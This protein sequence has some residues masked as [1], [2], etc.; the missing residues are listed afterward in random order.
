MTAV[1]IA[2]LFS[3]VAV[4]PSPLW[5][6]QFSVP[7][8]QTI[9]L[10]GVHTYNN[11]FWYYYDAINGV[12]RTDHGKGQFDELCR[13]IKGKKYSDEPCSM[14]VSKDGWRYVLFPEESSCCKYCN[15]TV[16]CGIIS[17]DWL[18][19]STYQGQKT[20]QG[21]LCNGWMKKGGE[22]NY[23][24][25]TADSLQEPCEFYEGYPTLADGINVW[26]YSTT[27]Y[28]T[29]PQDPKLFEVSSTCTSMCNL[30]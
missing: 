24:Y 11:T 10:N 14:I 28:K 21:R 20:I 6:E 7:I 2:A 30:S 13:S 4:P 16:G 19:N 9:R 29:G 3:V 27:Q 25:A 18:R 26:L 22:K 23:Y 12:S 1:L 8:N 5:D 15:T 17:R